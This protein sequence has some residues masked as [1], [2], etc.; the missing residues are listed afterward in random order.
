MGKKA[1]I[2][3]IVVL[4]VASVLLCIYD[5]VK[6]GN[7]LT[8]LS[9]VLS[10]FST[11]AIGVFA[12]F[13]NRN[14]QRRADEQA[15]LALMP[16]IYIQTALLERLSGMGNAVFNVYS[17][18]IKDEWISKI[19]VLI[20]FWFV[21]GPIVKLRAKEIM[22]DGKTFAFGDTNGETLRNEQVQIRFSLTIPKCASKESEYLLVMSYENI[23]GT[24]YQKCIR[25]LANQ[26]NGGVIVTA[27][28]KTHRD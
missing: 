7:I 4:F 28:E 26:A 18:S 22:V 9:G 2:I 13:Q 14:Y 8:A 11:I 19:Q 10:A 24:K 16:D 15:D 20:D 6:N 23:Y 27:M 25:F 21:K 17:A 1:I 12:L 3:L 5:F